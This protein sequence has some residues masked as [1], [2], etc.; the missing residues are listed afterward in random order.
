MWWMITAHI[1]RHIHNF[2]SSFLS[3]W[4]ILS[5]RNECT[6]DWFFSSKICKIC[7]CDLTDLPKG[8]LNQHQVSSNAV[9]RTDCSKAGQFGKHWDV[10]PTYIW[11][12]TKFSTWHKYWP[13]NNSSPYMES[14]AQNA[15]T[16]T[17]TSRP[18]LL[19]SCSWSQSIKSN[20][21]TKT[22]HL[23][24]GPEEGYRN[25]GQLLCTGHV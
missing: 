11:H 22:W 13:S 5:D 15:G 1:L 14:S 19:I 25:N 21:A 17:T 23:H 24:H 16:W 9:Q 8:Q 2:L 18:S 10:W 7:Q 6:G 4:N 20:S 3:H 12:L